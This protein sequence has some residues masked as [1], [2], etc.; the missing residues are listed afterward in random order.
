M[1]WIAWSPH[2]TSDQKGTWQ[3]TIRVKFPRIHDTFPNT[4][5][6]GNTDYI[7]HSLLH[8]Q[9]GSHS[10]TTWTERR[11][12]RYV[13]HPLTWTHPNL[14]RQLDTAKLQNDW[15]IS[16]PF[17]GSSSIITPNVDIYR[18]E[19]SLVH[20]RFF[21]RALLEPQLTSY[22]DYIDRQMQYRQ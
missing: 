1:Y 21:P 3:C 10:L 20:Q 18:W 8:L 2:T 4:S 6:R 14:F 11:R 17:L 15:K 16:F 19:I 22:L 7:H 5:F 12:L 13:C 9:K